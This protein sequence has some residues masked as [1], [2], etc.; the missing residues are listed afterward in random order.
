MDQNKEKIR[1][2]LKNP[3]DKGGSASQ[4]SWKIS[5]VYGEGAV[6]KSAACKWFARFRS[7]IPM[8][9]M[10]PVLVGRLPKIL[11]K[12]GILAVL[13]L[14]AYELNINHQTVLNHLQKAG[15]KTKID[16]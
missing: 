4:A 12:I 6:S 14:L 1:Y 13:A 10:I 9:K 3:L 11:S 5:D 16:V 7:K 8:P 15:F 2:I